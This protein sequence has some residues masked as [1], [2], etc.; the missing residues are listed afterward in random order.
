M[1]RMLLAIILAAGAAYLLG[2]IN[3]AIIITRLFAKD[4]IRTHGSGNAG[5]TNVLRTLGKGPAALTFIG[6]FAKGAVAV[7][8]GD[9]FIQVVGGQ[10]DW[11]LGG[12][13]A[14]VFALLG[15]VYPVFY[16][17]KGGKGIL[18]SAGV[19][20]VLDPIALAIVLALFLIV[21][22]KSRI[23]SLASITAAAAYPFATLL[24]RYF[25]HAALGRLLPDV[26]MAAAVGA[27]IIFMHRENI[28][29]LRAGTEH[30]FGQKKEE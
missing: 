29:R 9:F 28:K 22:A 17:F 25:Q 15:H 2:S 3:F 16:G 21:V 14:A 30:R 18:V 20:L 19:M 23:V 11:E 13:L 27:F 5:M 26:I 10:P 6:D 24:V 4:D 12:Y 1:F 7:L 8:L